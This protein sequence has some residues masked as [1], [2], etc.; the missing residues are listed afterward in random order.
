MLV[1]AGLGAWM[2]VK[3][4]RAVA[5]LTPA[6]AVAA[7]GRHVRHLRSDVSAALDEGRRAKRATEQELRQAARSRPAIDITARPA[8]TSPPAPE[9]WRGPPAPEAWRGPPAPEAWRGL[10]PNPSEEIP[11]RR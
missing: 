1:G 6:G 3:V 7:A 4:Q 11:E 5:R 2:V 9:A 8:L 10:P